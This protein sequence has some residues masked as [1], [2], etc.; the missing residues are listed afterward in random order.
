LPF[1]KERTG[2]TEPKGFAKRLLGRVLR[3]PVS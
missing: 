2:R 1:S 3:D